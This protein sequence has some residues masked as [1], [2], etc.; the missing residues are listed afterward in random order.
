M[1]VATEKKTLK[2]ELISG[3]CQIYTASSTLQVQQHERVINGA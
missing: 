3:F 1:A 2:P